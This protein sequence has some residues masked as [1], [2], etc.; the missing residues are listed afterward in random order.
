[1]S[2]WNSLNLGFFLFDD[3]DFSGSDVWV[4]LLTM[5]YVDI[6]DTTGT[7]YSMADFAG[8][9]DERGDFPRSTWAF[10]ADAIGT[11]LGSWMGTPDTTCYIES[12]AGIHA[13]GRTGITAIVVGLLFFVSLFFNPIFASIPPWATG[14]ALVIVGALMMESVVKIKWDDMRQAM[15]AFVSIIIMPFTYSIAYGIHSRYTLYM[16][17]FEYVRMDTN[18]PIVSIVYNY[19]YTDTR[20]IEPMDGT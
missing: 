18:V 8:L 17:C 5:L 20:C 9:V 19:M 12:A 7:L 13:G 2:F 6:L 1:M 16:I 15:P 3:V 4:A 10:T 11:I 14:P